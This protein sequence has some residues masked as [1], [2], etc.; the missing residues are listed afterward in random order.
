MKSTNNKSLSYYIKG[1]MWIDDSLLTPH[2]NQGDQG[3]V[4]YERR[5]QKLRELIFKYGYLNMPL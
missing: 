2:L 3:R 4:F 1:I 5:A